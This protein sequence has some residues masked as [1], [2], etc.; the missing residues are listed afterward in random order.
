MNVIH[1]RVDRYGSN[2]VPFLVNVF[3]SRLESYP[4]FHDCSGNCKKRGLDRM[5][6]HQ[7]LVSNTLHTSKASPGTVLEPITNKIWSPRITCKDLFNKYNK[8][9]PELFFD[10]STFHEVRQIY[11]DAYGGGQ[12][13]LK[14][15]NATVIHLRLNDL[16]TDFNPSTKEITWNNKFRT[17]IPQQ[18]L[19]IEDGVKL[20]NFCLSKFECPVFLS[21]TVFSDIDYAICLTILKESNLQVDNYSDYILGSSDADFDLFNMISGKNFIS[22]CST[23]SLLASLLHENP[24]S[25]DSWLHYSDLLGRKNHQCSRFPILDWRD[26]K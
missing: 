8:T 5:I 16:L 26:S 24:F 17:T 12:K 25:A 9:F 2:A 11:F 6:M 15:Q 20:V 22:S 18:Y 7:F 23:F 10:S 14:T 21:S 1:T 3:K 19:S 13:S 4:L